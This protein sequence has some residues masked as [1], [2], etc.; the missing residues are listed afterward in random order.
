MKQSTNKVVATVA[1]TTNFKFGS[2]QIPAQVVFHQKQYTYCMIP[3]VQLLPGR[4][5]YKEK[6]NF[7]N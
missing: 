6:M 1:A 5:K 2:M 7:L 4:K 3:L